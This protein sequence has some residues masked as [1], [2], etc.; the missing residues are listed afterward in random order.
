M[1]CQILFCA[2]RA[3]AVLSG[4]YAL[5]PTAAFCNSK[6]R[7]NVNHKARFIYKIYS[8]ITTNWGTIQDLENDFYTKVSRIKRLTSNKRDLRMKLSLS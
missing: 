6:L 8:K 4:G 5:S 7:D 2:K 3:K 1:L